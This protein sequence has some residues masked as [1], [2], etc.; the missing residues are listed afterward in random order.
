MTNTDKRQM[1]RWTQGLDESFLTRVQVLSD[2]EAASQWKRLD[3][4]GFAYS[5]SP[6]HRHSGF[7]GR[8]SDWRFLAWWMDAYNSGLN[9]EAVSNELRTEL[10]WL[11]HKEVCLLWSPRKALRLSFACLCESWAEVIAECDDN[12]FIVGGDEDR[13]LIRFGPVGDVSVSSL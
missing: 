5:Q 3:A 6:K 13:E 9:R 1:P 10:P 2:A 7:S 11:D 8:K 4:D 12:F